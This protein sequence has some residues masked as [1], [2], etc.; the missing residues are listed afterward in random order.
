MTLLRPPTTSTAPAAPL[1]RRLVPLLVLPLSLLACVLSGTPWLRA[2][3]ADVMA[4][5]LVGTAL[6]S[7]LLPVVV[8]AIGVRRLWLTALVDIA[9]FVFFTTLV[10]LRDPLALSALWNGLI[11]GPSQILTFALPLISPRTLLVAP[12]A[13]VWLT[14]AVIGECIGRGWHS[15]L[16]PAAALG[17]FGLAYGAT[18]RA[19]TDA[20]AGRREDV[21]LAGALLLTLLLLRAA[22]SWL[23][24]DESA[25]AAQAEGVLPLRGLGWGVVTSVVVALVAALVVQS[26]AFTGTPA[27]ARRV[28]PVDTTDPVRPLSFVAGLRPENPK[29]AGERLFGVSLNRPASRYVAIADVDTYDGDGWNFDREFRPSGGVVPTDP[30]PDL[31]PRTAEVTQRYTIATGPLAG[32]PWLPF[33]YR[34]VDV[35]GVAINSDTTSGMIIPRAGL[36]GGATYDVVSTGSTGSFAQLPSDAAFATSAPPSATFLPLAVRRA[37]GTVVTS[38]QNETGTRG[39]PALAFLQAVLR[40]F[41]AN[42]ALSGGPASVPR[43][44]S[45]APSTTAR[46]T[47]PPAPSS[48]AA[49]ASG[50]TVPRTGG[51]GFAAVLASILGAT[52]SATPEQYATLVALLARASGVPSRVV[53]G[54]KI[55]DGTGA[56]VPA[57][58][59]DVRAG[60]AWTWVEIPVRGR[61]WMVLDAAPTRYGDRSP[62]PSVSARPTPSPSPSS[63]NVLITR[64]PSDNGNAVAPPSETPRTDA[65]DATVWLF[66]IGAVLLLILGTV[67]LLVWRKHRRI[68]RRRSG[69]PRHRLI[70]AWQ[71]TLDVL[72]ESGLEGLRALT[73]SEVAAATSRR[74]GTDTEAPA[75]ELAELADAAIFRPSAPIEA[76]AADRAWQGHTELRRRIRQGQTARQRL[77]SGLAYQRRSANQYRGGVPARRR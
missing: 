26:G 52:R 7:V 51:T 68:R 28:P 67:G 29:A 54:F 6:L 61:G 44:A 57:G 35:T 45:P 63:T 48:P 20:D 39:G 11:H 24:Q 32:S 31:R 5:P 33:Q 16:P 3:P 62:Q 30:D 1:V 66:V 12:V 50:S 77:R 74:F 38:L 64:A 76:A 73:G 17:T 27:T 69:D 42:Y 2:F 49:G 37:I 15:V 56:T 71:E 25:E 13:L 47:A 60:Q 70:G 19:V 75:R 14:G 72:A 4:V 36:R 41:R 55:G 58:T 10:T 21:L 22:Q 40:D 18:A 34:P 8:I 43:S 46:S 9:G 53:T 59:Y 23:D 65:P